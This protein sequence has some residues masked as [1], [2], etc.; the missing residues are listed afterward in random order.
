MRPS[1]S[2]NAAARW[3]TEQYGEQV[4]VAEFL[5][6]LE[7]LELLVKDGEQT[8]Q[9]TGPV[10]WQRLGRALFSPVAWAFYGLLVAAA[11]AAVIRTPELLPRYQHLFFTHSSLVVLTLGIVLGQVPW[12]LAHEAFHALVGHAAR[13]ALHP[14]DR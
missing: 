4:D 14:L 7:E 13:P 3:Y 11:A 9:A 6:V 8:A 5:E 2:P 1:E 12:I 10:R